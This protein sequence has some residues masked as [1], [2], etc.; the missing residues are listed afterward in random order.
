MESAKDENARARKVWGGSSWAKVEQSKLNGKKG[1]R[2]TWV[3][4]PKTPPRVEYKPA[5]KPK[6]IKLSDKARTVNK[7]LLKGWIVVDIA[8]VLGVSHQAISQMVK[9]YNLP[10]KEE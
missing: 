1:G 4:K 8:D 9:R 6:L 5:P 2:P 7:L 3:S 10:R